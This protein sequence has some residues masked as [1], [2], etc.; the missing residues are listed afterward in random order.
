[1]KIENCTIEGGAYVVYDILLVEI[2]RNTTRY[3]IKSLK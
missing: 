3:P 2:I 1:M